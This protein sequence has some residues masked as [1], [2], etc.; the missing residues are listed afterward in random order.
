MVDMARVMP[1]VG[2]GRPVSQSDIITAILTLPRNYQD[3]EAL[4]VFPGLGETWRVETAIRAWNRR[5]PDS[6][7]RRLLIAGT[8]PDEE[9]WF[10]PSPE[11]LAKFGLADMTDVRTQPSARQTP[12][13]AAW[14]LE[15]IKA[16][17]I[18]SLS[19]FVSPYHL[20]RAF[21]TLVAEFDK[22]GW[23]IP[24]LPIP[25]PVAPSTVIPE[26]A[27][28]GYDGWQLMPE[29]QRKYDIYSAEGDV[30]DPELVRSYLQWLTMQSEFP[31]YEY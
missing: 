28:Q 1:R 21:C 18:T 27:D 8:N 20:V 26:F 19:L 23:C 17:E 10:E 14:V 2:E 7:T 9:Q 15:Q 29:E 5:G 24:M 22:A 16:D 30:A 12:E 6:P 11:N 13:Q 4:A 25:V 3:T 31:I